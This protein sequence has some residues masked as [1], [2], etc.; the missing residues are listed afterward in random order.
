VLRDVRGVA[1]VFA[2]LADDTRL[3]LLA[4]LSKGSRCSITHLA[5]G[6]AVSRQ[7]ITKHLRVLQDAGLVHGVRVGRE[8]L[9]ELKPKP[10]D[11][12]RDALDRI[13]R[14]WDEALARLKQFVE[15]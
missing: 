6:S 11:E 14:Q 8:N 5:E 9:F 7:A 13:S 4:R 1:P 12:A 2:A 15:E 3:K 10:L